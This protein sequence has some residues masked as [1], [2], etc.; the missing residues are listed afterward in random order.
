M[1]LYDRCIQ[2]C[3]VGGMLEYYGRDVKDLRSIIHND[4]TYCKKMHTLAGNCVTASLEKDEIRVSDILQGGDL[5]LCFRFSGGN[6]LDL[7]VEVHHRI[8]LS[9][10]HLIQLIRIVVDSHA[11]IITVS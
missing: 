8:F 9:V 5:A 7:Q 6:F 11:T 3:H 10:L 1:F 2:S 4:I